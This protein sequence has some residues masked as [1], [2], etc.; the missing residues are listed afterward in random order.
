MV[1]ISKATN[2]IAKLE[3]LKEEDYTLESWQIFINELTT[4]KE[5]L[6]DITSSR[7]V[8]DIVVKADYIESQLIKA[9]ITDTNKT[10]LKIAID[11]ASL[12]SEES[13]E[14][15]IP[16]VVDEFKAALS[17]ANEVYNNTSATQKK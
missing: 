6:N 2:A 13:L 4:L 12:I 11:I 16:V 9:E 15:V 5:Q 10:A 14:N 3:E 8:L 17:E 7:E 1:N